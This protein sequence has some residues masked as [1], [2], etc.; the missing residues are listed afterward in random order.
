MLPEEKRVDVV[1]RDVEMGFWS[2]VVFLVK[3]A[4]AAIPAGLILALF[5]GALVVVLKAW[6]GV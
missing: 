6:L 5:I 2:M 4:L 3:L 1:V